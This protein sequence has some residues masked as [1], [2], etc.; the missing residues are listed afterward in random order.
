MQLDNSRINWVE[1]IMK[2]QMQYCEILGTNINVTTM[3]ETIE[4]M[5][6]NL[7][8]LK[9]N[10]ICVSNV[11]TTVM[12]YENLE[13][14]KIQNG[15]A[16]ALPDGKPLSIISKKRGYPKAERV[17]GPDLMPEIFQLSQQNGWT[18][19]FYGGS[20]TT[21]RTLELKL[22]KQYPNM[23]IVGLYS[24]PFRMLTEEEDYNIIEEINQLNPDFL[25]IGLGAPKQ[26]QWMYDHKDKVQGLMIG[27]G[28]A[29]DFL[30]GTT[31]R[32]PKWMQKMS[33]E[34][35]Y[36]LLSNPRRLWKRYFITNT[37]FLWLIL[38]RK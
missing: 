27:V 6:E 21:I 20:E 4:Y 12:S 18:H 23:K 2:K 38:R 35:L 36:R 10:Y 5:K 37:K 32:A 28:A 8:D 33:I 25:W 15:G 17:S 16:M 29:F 22:K 7:E 19:Y 34:W 24:P 30:A 31:K 1:E 11:H 9:G 3:S 26:E 13:Y 14:K